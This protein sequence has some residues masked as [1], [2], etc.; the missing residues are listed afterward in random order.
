MKPDILLMNIGQVAT[1][2]GHS[3]SPKTGEDMKELSIIE[4]GAIAIKEGI[5]T[6][7]GTTAEVLAHITEMP[8]LPPLEF[9]KMLATPGFIDSHTH[10]E[11][12][13]EDLHGDSCCRRGH[14]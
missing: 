9:P 1:L 3:N 11:T 4:G 12:C 5:I 2:Q 13:R 7:V 14:S 8:D 6:A 10:H